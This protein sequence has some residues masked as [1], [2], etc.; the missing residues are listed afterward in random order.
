MESPKHSSLLCARLSQAW[1]GKSLCR[2]FALPSVLPTP[3]RDRQSRKL[4]QERVPHLPPTRPASSSQQAAANAYP[5]CRREDGSKDRSCAQ[6][7]QTF[8]ARGAHV[9]S[10]LRYSS[11]AQLSEIRL[12]D[13]CKRL[14]N[15]LQI[16]TAS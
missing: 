4:H 13:G 11:Q 6:S 10:G 12:K 16:V 2:Q 9:R 5:Y 3:V 7:P 1:V 14:A 8:L 15:N